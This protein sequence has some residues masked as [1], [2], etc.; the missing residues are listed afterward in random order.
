[1]IVG[2]PFRVGPTIMTAGR[3][4]GCQKTMSPESNHVITIITT[5]TVFD[6]GGDSPSLTKGKEKIIKFLTKEEYMHFKFAVVVSSL[7]CLSVQDLF[8]S[9]SLLFMSKSHP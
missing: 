9:N 2:P 6:L 8:C 4:A 5:F 1:M 3:S 7:V